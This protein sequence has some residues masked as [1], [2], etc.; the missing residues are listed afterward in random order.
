MSGP[1][2]D[3]GGDTALADDSDTSVPDDRESRVRRLTVGGG[4]AGALTP[5]PRVRLATVLVAALT[6][7][8]V[9][10]SVLLWQ[11][12]QEQPNPARQKAE[13]RD[14]THAATV[15]NLEALMAADHGDAT[16][17]FERWTTATTG[18]L[19]AQLGG[20]RRAITRRLRSTEEVTTARTV[21]AA[22]TSWDDAAGTARL[23]AVL[24]L[25]TT[26]TEG[27]TKRTVRYLAMAQRVEGRWLLSAV[28]QLGATS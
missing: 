27:E 14:A 6:V 7:G 18:R 23:L 26:S 4:D 15:R 21:E 5:G 22:L 28:Q 13:A 17:T 19:H 3:H 12:T 1:E 25:S 2:R 10:C 20:E 24:E 16:G 8:M 9:A 11:Q